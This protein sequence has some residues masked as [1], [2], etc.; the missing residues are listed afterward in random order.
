MELL[1]ANFFNTTTQ[2][3]AASGQSTV[4]YLLNPNT[5]F[6]FYDI[7]TAA[8][9]PLFTVTF[10]NPQ[11]VNRIALLDHNFKDFTVEYT[12]SQVFLTTGAFPLT[13]T[14]QTTVIDFLNNSETSHFF[15]GPTTL[16]N[17]IQIY[18]SSTSDGYDERYL[19]Y[20]VISSIRTD[21]EG[22]IPNA[23]NFIV[24]K[25][26][27][28]IRHKMSNGGTRIHTLS[29][30]YESNLTLDYISETLKDTLADIYASHE[31]MIFVPF[32]TST[33]WDSLAFPCIWSGDFSFNY[34]DNASEAG[35]SGSIELLGTP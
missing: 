32:P 2:F 33:G 25:V 29:E 4:V 15:T 27:T 6:R 14:A 26:P 5:R 8:A 19:G 9:S 20:L 1:S 24:K 12:D 3:S 11:Y 18:V 28:Q 13:T 10:D 31:E 21:F 34:S 23:Q 16:V 35:Y 30:T 22:R 7:A 17:S